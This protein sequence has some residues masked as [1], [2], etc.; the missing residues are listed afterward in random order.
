MILAVDGKV[1]IWRFWQ[2]GRSEHAEDGAILAVILVLAFGLSDC[3]GSNVNNE[4][5]AANRSS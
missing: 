3:W 1:M 2:P 4:F 5:S